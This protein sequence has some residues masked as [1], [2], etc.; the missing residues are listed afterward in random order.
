MAPDAIVNVRR[1]GG[2]GGG[3]CFASANYGEKDHIGAREKKVK[4]PG[5]KK[6]T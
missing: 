5:K 6:C 4:C 2:K 1:K 3:E